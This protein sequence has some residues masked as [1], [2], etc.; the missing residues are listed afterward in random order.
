LDGVLIVIAKTPQPGKV[1]TR[2]VPPLT[3]Q[4]ACEVAGAC[5]RDTLRAASAVPCRRHVLLLD[6]EPG[7]WVPRGWEI[8]AQHGDGLAERLATGFADVADT[9]LVIAMDTPQV[10]PATLERALIALGGTHDSAFGPATDGGFW[11]LGLRAGV[12]PRAVFDGIPMSVAHTGAAQRSRL[13]DLEP[14]QDIDT[15]ADLV[16]VT[17]MHPHLELAATVTALRATRPAPVS[18]ATGDHAS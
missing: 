17:A 5:I 2:L 3:P 15:M 9:A 14:L 6:G 4:E 13:G 12:D 10:D 11:A 16:G 18:W 1:K 8:V 7:D